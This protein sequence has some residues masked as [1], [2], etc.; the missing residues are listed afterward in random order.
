MS[1][2]KRVYELQQ[3][4]QSIQSGRRQYEEI[5][6]KISRNAACEQAGIN[7]AEAEKQL[8]GLEKQYKELDSEAETLRAQVKQIDGKLYGGK[9]NNPKELQGYEQE[10]NMLRAN[11]SRKD[12]T[13]LELMEKI[14]AGKVAAGKLKEVCRGAEAAWQ[15][16][17]VELQVQA[18]KLNGEL[19]TLENRRK[20]ILGS[21]DRETLAIF[22][23]I[24][25]RKGQAVVKV[26]QGRCLGCRVTL[27]VSELQHVRGNAIVTCSNC[28]RI[29]Y[30][31]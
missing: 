9:I 5:Q 27:S 23:G 3:V 30:L 15:A 13:L 7:L 17:K 14:E 1:L 19:E 20:E 28:G 11:L 16:E 12:D 25:S 31:S 6:A 21:V 8:A 18:D 22:E 10:G 26:E 29:L 24:R 2:A 4:E